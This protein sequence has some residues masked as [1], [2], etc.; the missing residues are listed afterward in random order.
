MITHQ[1]DIHKLFARLRKR[2]LFA[3][4]DW[5]CC[6]S[7]GMYGA[8]QESKPEQGIVFY[9]AQ[10][11]SVAFG[12]DAN[13]IVSRRNRQ[14]LKKNL[15]LTFAGDTEEHTKAVAEIVLE[16]AK[17][18]NIPAYWNG[19]TGTRIQILRKA[20]TPRFMEK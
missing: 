15:W 16:E 12:G 19:D 2:G 6:Q 1:K 4:E 17:R 7:C 20:V 10:D 8:E 5:T 13:Y 9:H 11:T 18:L 3:K 14:E